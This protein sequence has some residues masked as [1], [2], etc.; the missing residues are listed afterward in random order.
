MCAY[1]IIYPTLQLVSLDKCSNITQ[2]LLCRS[3]YAGTKDLKT[4][5]VILDVG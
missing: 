4:N 2:N 1:T 5:Y 3:H